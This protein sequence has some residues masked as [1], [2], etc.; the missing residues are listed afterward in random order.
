M[1]L[2]RKIKR[3]AWR[4]F[5]LGYPPR[6]RNDVS[7]GDAF[8]WE[9]LIH[10]GQTFP[11]KII[12]V[13]RDGD[14]GTCIKTDCFLNDQLRHEYRDRVGTRKSIE[15]TQLLSSAL[16]QLQVSVPKAEVDAETES[17]KAQSHRTGEE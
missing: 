15:Y 9:W 13:S 2:R 14:Y 5:I 10:C 16:K 8:N 12:I 4:R 17:L 11:G 7:I 1:P 3:L 6:K